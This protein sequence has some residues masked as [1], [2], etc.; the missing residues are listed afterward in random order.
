M[1]LADER[2]AAERR[3]AQR[4][5]WDP[6][7]GPLMKKAGA[8]D[9][10]HEWWCASVLCIRVLAG[11][12]VTGGPVQ[13]QS[14]AGSTEGSGRHQDPFRSQLRQL[15]KASRKTRVRTCTLSHRDSRHGRCHL[16]ELAE[17]LSPTCD[18]AGTDGVSNRRCTRVGS[19]Q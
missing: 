2:D 18:G 15:W 19:T 9:G 7:A 8:L 13:T 5:G 16:S 11:C 4:E 1:P 14:V 12:V 6:R 3:A 10:A 17:P